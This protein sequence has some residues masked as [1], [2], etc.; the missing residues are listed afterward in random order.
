MVEKLSKKT[1]KK[2][3]EEILEDK[4]TEEGIVTLGEN[5]GQLFVRIPQIIKER[6]DLNKGDRLLFRAYN[7]KNKPKLEVKIYNEKED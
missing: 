3:I 1:I 7:Y 4:Y 2:D 6:F 5:R